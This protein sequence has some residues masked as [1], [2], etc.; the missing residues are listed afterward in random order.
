MDILEKLPGDLRYRD[1]IDIELVSLD[2]KEKKIKGSLKCCEFYLIQY[3]ELA[4][5]A[6]GIE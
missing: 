2:E 5:L 4:L 6:F 3:G 1:V